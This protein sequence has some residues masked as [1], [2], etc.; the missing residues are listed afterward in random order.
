MDGGGT[1]EGVRFG[2]IQGNN[3]M[4]SRF[5]ALY[6]M[7]EEEGIGTKHYANFFQFGKEDQ[8]EDKIK[9]LVGNNNK[10]INLRLADKELIE[11]N[12]KV[13][14]QKGQLGLQIKGLKAS[15]SGCN[16]SKLGVRK[17]GSK[18]RSSIN[19]FYVGSIK[20]QPTVN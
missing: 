11:E 8:F 14:C 10:A 9:V 18:V 16:G 3:R 17:G 20:K 19:G 7:E 2:S 6:I 1:L 5:N 15:V 12:V 13:V 4:G